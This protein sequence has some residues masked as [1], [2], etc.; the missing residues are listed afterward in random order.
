M[1]HYRI[2][3]SVKEGEKVSDYVMVLQALDAEA[4]ETW[5]DDNVK[6]KLKFKQKVVDEQ[7][8][9]LFG[10]LLYDNWFNAGKNYNT[11]SK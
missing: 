4:V 7:I 3:F 10:D 9:V 2:D 1:S 8:T 6:K 5:F 11:Y